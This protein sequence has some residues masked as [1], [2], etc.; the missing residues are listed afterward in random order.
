MALRAPKTSKPPAKPLASSFPPARGGLLQRECACGGAPGLDD[1]CDECRQ[2]DMGLQRLSAAPAAAPARS[3]LAPLIVHDVLRSPG[4]PLDRAARASLE[5]RFG[6]DFSRVRIHADAKAAESARAVAAHAYTVG[7]DIVF[8]ASRYAPGTESGRRL[9][10]HELTHVVQ[11]GFSRQDGALT[12][13]PEG[14]AYEQQADAIAREAGARHGMDLEPRSILRGVIQRDADSDDYKQ[15]YQDG[16]NGGES[17]PGPRDG[18]ALAD[19]NAGYAKGHD[20]FSQQTSSAGAPGPEATPATSPPVAAAAEAPTTSDSGTGGDRSAYLDQQFKGW[21][22]E[23]NWPLAAE[24]LNGFN[25]DDIKARL[26]GLT[27]DQITN[28]HQ[29]AL[30]N[31]RVGPQSQLA[32]LT[33]PGAPAAPMPGVDSAPT[34]GIVAGSVF[35]GA[36]PNIPGPPGPPGPFGPGVVELPKISEPFPLGPTGGA[37]VVEAEGALVTGEVGTATVAGAGAATIAAAVVGGLVVGL[38]LAVGVPFVIAHAEK[39]SGEVDPDEVKLPGGVPPDANLEGDAGA[40]L[41]A[42]SDL[43][44][45]GFSETDAELD[46]VAS[47]DE[48]EDVDVAVET[49]Q[50]P[51]GDCAEDRHRTLQDDINFKCKRLP[52]GCTPDMGCRQLK[53]N[54]YRNERCARARDQMNSECFKGG[55]PGHKQAASAAWLAAQ[56]CRELYRKNKC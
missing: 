24:A 43:D 56:N 28:L 32:Q 7:S 54:W 35:P 17:Q 25:S 27:Q 39:V 49:S 20:E 51:P 3:N 31:P 55:D 44:A 26:A 30:D 2:T 50:S 19:Y 15:G 38:A 45:G 11:Q 21:V 18:D 29:G 5:P 23:G 16:L 13:G 22:A 47:A 53:R 6:H 42:D 48:A 14:D 1:K 4:Q 10:A 34:A 37:G 36:T 52:R 8:G 9:L 41:P 12:V 46:A 33:E 40:P